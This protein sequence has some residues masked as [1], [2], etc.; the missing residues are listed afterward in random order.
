MQTVILCGG[1]GTR[2]RDVSED[3]PKPMIPIG[4][5]PILWHIMKYYAHF[6]HTDFVLCLGYKSW[7]IKQYFLDYYR[8]SADL[9]VN[10]ANPNSPV[11][12]SHEPREDWAITLA[13]TGLPTMT[14]GRIKKIS[15][16]ITGSDFMVTYGDGVA[17]VDVPRLLE[18]HRSHGRIGTMTAVT[19][20]GRFGEIEIDDSRIT[21]F[22]EKPPVTRGRINGGFFVF[23][24]EF[25]DRLSND[26]S[27]ILERGPLAELAADGELMAYKHDGFWQCMDNSRDY[28]ALNGMW[29]EGQAPW[30]VWDGAARPRIAAA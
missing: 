13:E 24:R 22:S 14:G 2:I 20:P 23:R 30:K 28:H 11:V 16:Y 29:A 7:T 27:L 25:L 8:A 12:L 1:M 19:S 3:V 5:R 4:D 10:L 21:E 18:F 15:R 17:D 9:K 6:G 26:P